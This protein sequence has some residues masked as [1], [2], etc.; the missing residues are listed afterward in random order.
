MI[1]T[2]RNQRH[3]KQVL[4]LTRTAW[5][6]ILELADLYGWMP[7]GASLSGHWQDIDIPWNGY[8]FEFLPPEPARQPEQGQLI[9]LEDAINL[10]DAL[11]QAFYEYEPLRVPPSFY[12]F[13]PEN[14][15]LRNR[16][17]IGAISAVIDLCRQGAFWVEAYHN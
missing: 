7:F 9:I 13:E 3:P 15:H 8:D 12:L 16:P 2:L 4:H 10:A 6:G 14:E 1:F 5:F 11:E 17:S